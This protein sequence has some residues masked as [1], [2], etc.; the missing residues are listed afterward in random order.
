M[1]PPEHDAYTRPDG[2]IRIPP[3]AVHAALRLLE[4]AVS[5]GRKLGY[6]AAV[7][8]DWSV[9]GDALAEEACKTA[10]SDTGT[11][12]TGAAILDLA[13]L[14][15]SQVAARLGCSDRFVRRLCAIGR[16]KATRVGRQWVIHEI[17]LDQFRFGG[18]THE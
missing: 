13:Q 4:E 5:W 8:R 7:E 10:S 6:S 2:S 9:V 17:D 1:F 15:V 14:N 12:I 16:I 3:H 18:A 11:A